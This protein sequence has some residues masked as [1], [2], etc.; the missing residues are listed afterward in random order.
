M[1][2][3]QA[4]LIATRQYDSGRW[5]L[6]LSRVPIFPRNH[7]KIGIKTNRTAQNS[8]WNSSF[9]F[10]VTSLLLLVIL[11]FGFDSTGQI[12]DAAAEN[13]RKEI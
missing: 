11:L 1:K 7:T 4:E 12:N 6:R 9:W 8:G 5:K 10:A 2:T 3:S 13:S